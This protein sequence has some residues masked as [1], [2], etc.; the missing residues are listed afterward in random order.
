VVVY[1]RRRRQ[2][3]AEFA[4]Q[5]Q[6]Q[7]LRAG[8]GGDMKPPGASKPPAS[9][10]AAATCAPGTQL[11]QQEPL[12]PSPAGKNPHLRLLVAA[13]HHPSARTSPWQAAYAS[14]S[15]AAGRGSANAA[16]ASSD[17]FSFPAL[18]K[19][20]VPSKDDHT[21]DAAAT[22]AAP[23]TPAPEPDSAAAATV[24]TA[25][26][27]D[28]PQAAAATAGPLPRSP[29]GRARFWAQYGSLGAH[30]RCAGGRVAGRRQMPATH[31]SSACAAHADLPACLD[32]SPAC[33]QKHTVQ[34]GEGNA[35]GQGQ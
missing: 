3:R 9:P 20:K 5:Q 15:R 2:R 26:A 32:K 25:T 8:D 29:E 14:A 24:G 18:G 19:I 21:P 31:D 35:V 22:G 30:G 7:G 33:A 4:L 34:G 17:G 11:Q 16:T 28:T 23:A 10:Q 12:P 27:D 6:Q 1:T 13:N